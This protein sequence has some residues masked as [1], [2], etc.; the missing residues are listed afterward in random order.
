MHRA[1]GR[2]DR[3]RLNWFNGTW[4]R[5]LPT[6]E[7]AG[8]LEP[9]LPAAWDRA[10]VRTIVPL[11]Q[12]R[13]VTLAEAPELIAFL[14]TDD[15]GLD[16]ALLVPK[17]REKLDTVTALSRTTVALR[18]L[19]P[20]TPEAIEAA[21]GAVAA[22]VDW[23]LRDVTIAVRSA[24]TG[25]KIGPPLYGSMA[26]LGRARTIERLEAAQELLEP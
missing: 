17:K 19:D 2:W 13:M 8:R 20:F 14:F 18:Y 9:F 22:D 1:G 10:T 5:R 16:P 24:V 25:R 3:E 12:E 6:D 21:L 11:I 23:S 26:L 4:I 15:L 7:L